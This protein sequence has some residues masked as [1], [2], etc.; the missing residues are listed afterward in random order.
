MRDHVTLN[1]RGVLR[2]GMD[3]NFKALE[4]NGFL[5]KSDYTTLTKE[6]LSLLNP[7]RVPS[8]RKYIQFTSLKYDVY[9]EE[10][11]KFKPNFDSIEDEID[12]LAAPLYFVATFS[13]TLFPEFQDEYFAPLSFLTNKNYITMKGLKVIEPSMYH[14]LTRAQ[15]DLETVVRDRIRSSKK[16]EAIAEDVAITT[17]FLLP[18][19]IDSEFPMTVILAVN[20][21]VK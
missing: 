8:I 1:P 9:C 17:Q 18:F 5:E 20:L 2:L 16:F 4:K 6:C 19:E 13:S 7:V 15:Y 12:L 11:S 10:V 21:I 14:S 3:I